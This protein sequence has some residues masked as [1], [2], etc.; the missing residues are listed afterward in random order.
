MRFRY[1]VICKII[2]TLN[3]IA[4]LKNALLFGKSKF[5]DFV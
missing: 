1:T 3:A 2:Y 4:F 5:L